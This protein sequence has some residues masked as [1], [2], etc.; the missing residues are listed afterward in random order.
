MSV[1]DLPVRPLST[2]DPHSPAT[3]VRVLGSFRFLVRGVS[4]VPSAA[5][6]RQLLALLVLNADQTV[7]TD[8]IVDELWGDEP[9]RS[10]K[11]AVQTYILSLRKL[12][13]NADGTDSAIVARTVLVHSGNG[14][15]LTLPAAAIDAQRF[16]LLARRGNGD[17]AV[18]QAH[19]AATALAAALDEWSGTVLSDVE[20]GARLQAERSRLES[21]R[22]TIQERRIEADLRAGRHLEVIG[23]LTGLVHHH[24]LNEQLHLQLMRAQARCGRR[25]E[26][27]ETF[28]RLRRHLD[29]ELGIEPSRSVH[30]LV[31]DILADSAADRMFPMSS[32]A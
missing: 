21:M 1:I 7:S 19:S 2:D 9:P 25:G 26:A 14:Y 31:R 3:E 24:P 5:K 20:L 16:E 28:H 22:L 29:G 8:T 11:T 4:C 13:A 18:G 12:L 27:L 30:D 10:V 32:S 15:R 23:E 6:P 17:F